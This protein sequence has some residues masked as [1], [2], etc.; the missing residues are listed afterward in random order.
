MY[1][2]NY[3][4]QEWILELQRQD[5]SSFPVFQVIPTL[6]QCIWLTEQGQGQREKGKWTLGFHSGQEDPQIATDGEEQR[7]W[8]SVQL[9]G[10][11]LADWDWRL[12]GWLIQHLDTALV[13]SVQWGRKWEGELMGVGVEGEGGWL[14]CVLVYVY[15]HWINYLINPQNST[16]QYE[17]W[18]PISK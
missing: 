8:E 3:E 2:L 16:K 15:T 17:S 6:R 4:V 5:N 12:E 13:S 10:F 1:C 18:C 7:W 9:G 11:D 14:P